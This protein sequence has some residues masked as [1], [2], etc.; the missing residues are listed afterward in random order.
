MDQSN[1][2]TS[3]TLRVHFEVY[4]Q[5]TFDL[6]LRH[7]PQANAIRRRLICGPWLCPSLVK[8]S[9]SKLLVEGTTLSGCA[10]VGMAGSSCSCRLWREL[11]GREDVGASGG[12]GIFSGECNNPCVR[13]T[14]KNVDYCPTSVWGV[15]GEIRKV[16]GLRE[17]NLFIFLTQALLDLNMGLSRGWKH[18]LNRPEI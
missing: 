16:R 8:L 4:S 11:L 9:I 6:R 5:L 10:S 3:R 17:G 7:V 12:D 15:L 18:H 2:T 13:T 1:Q 14:M